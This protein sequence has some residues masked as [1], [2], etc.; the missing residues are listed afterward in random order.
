[1]KGLQTPWSDEIVLIRE[2]SHKDSRGFPNPEPVRSDPPL[3]C[4]FE[5][6]VSQSEFYQSMRAGTQADAQAEVWT[7]D[8]E[9]FWPEGYAGRR[10][11]ELRGRKYTVVRSFPETQDTLTLILREVLR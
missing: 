6:G 1:M 5:D 11:C 10:L 9:A 2:E 8:Y 4:S 3:F 7:V